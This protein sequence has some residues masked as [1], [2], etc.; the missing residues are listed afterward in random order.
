MAVFWLNL[1]QAGI[2][3]QHW[4]QPGGARVWLVESPAIP[5]VDVQ[6]DFDAGGRR[7]PADKAGLASVTAA[8]VS[9]GVAARGADPALDENQLGEA[10]ADLGASF[11]AGAGGDRLSYSLRSLSYPDLLARA[12]A[13]AARQLAEPSFPEAIWQRERERIAASIRE[14]NTR[15]ATLAGRAFTQAV[16]GSH[17][18]GY[19]MTE[20]TLARITLADMRA[21]QARLILP[22]RARVS[23][24][25]ALNRQQADALVSRLL[26]R[27]PAGDAAACAPLPAVGEVAPLQASAERRIPFDSAQA[28]VLIGQPG[29]KRDDPDYFAL[30]VGNYTL[31]GGGFVSRLTQEVRE[32]RG[33]SYSVYS[34]FSPGLHAGAFTIGLQTRPD[35]AAQALKVSRDVLAAYVAEGPTPE[36]LKAAKDNLIGGF[37]L[38]L[39]S[40][41]KLLDN[42]ANIAWYDLPL[43]YLDTWTK[44]VEGQRGRHPGG[45]CPQAAAGADG[46]GGGGGSALSPLGRRG[47]GLGPAADSLF[48]ASPKKSKQKKGEPDASS[49]R[50]ATGTLRCSAQAGRAETRPSGSDICA[51]LSRLALCDSPTHDGKGT[52]G[53][54]T[55]P[56]EIRHFA[57]V[58]KNMAPAMYEAWGIRS[59][60]LRPG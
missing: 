28:H 39:D 29:Y 25:G 50:C 15:P 7:D 51:P 17:P 59:L 58:T 2:P 47:P 38:R 46:D 22:C 11:G 54:S 36:E 4:T 16:Y 60:P 56:P 18:Y 26:G 6:I 27:L 53:L 8:M 52:R 12:A 14:A 24:V 44:Q 3:I 21:Q 48:F 23:I 9:K 13:L 41:R 43:D 10:W 5:M 45:L 55:L 31:G 20:E 49:L 35:Q 57:R 33:L 19:E 30:L 1:A 40:N 37:A 34:Y 42:V 32:K